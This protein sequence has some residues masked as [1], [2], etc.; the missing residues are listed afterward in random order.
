[1]TGLCG[2]ER[3]FEAAL[4]GQVTDQQDQGG[5]SEAPRPRKVPDRSR[6]VALRSPASKALPTSALFTSNQPVSIRIRHLTRG[7]L[8]RN[9]LFPGP[10]STASP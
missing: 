1:M 9:A 10:Q 2:N 8:R 5:V 4:V 3:E 7:V 6:D